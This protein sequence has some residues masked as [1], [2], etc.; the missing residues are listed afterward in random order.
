MYLAVQKVNR[1]SLFII[2]FTF[3]RSIC[4]VKRVH[5]DHRMA[6]PQVAN[7]EEGMEGSY[8]YI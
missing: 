3:S 2:T 7:R 5:Y 1:F 4:H 6:H 8:E